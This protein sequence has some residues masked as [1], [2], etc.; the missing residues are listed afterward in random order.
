M[1]LRKSEGKLDSGK[2]DKMM[3][4][5]GKFNC[6]N[7]CDISAA[8]PCM[9]CTLG[10]LNFFWR[11]EKKASLSSM[12]TSWLSAGICWSNALVKT[13]VPGPSSIMTLAFWKEM[14]CSMRLLKKR[15]LGNTEPTMRLALKNSLRKDL[16]DIIVEL[17]RH[18][19]LVWC[20]WFAPGGYGLEKD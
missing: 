4:A 10:A 1:V 15:E 20:L 3:S 2:D 5:L 9:R 8:E 13:P 14:G 6:F 16:L 7:T 18:V 12:T 17:W 11:S 19:R